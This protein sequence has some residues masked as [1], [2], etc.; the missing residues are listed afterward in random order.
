MAIAQIVDEWKRAGWEKCPRC[1]VFF[2][3]LHTY[4]TDE[5][6]CGSCSDFLKEFPQHDY[7][8]RKEN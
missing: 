4:N 5:T 8:T 7:R 3:P 6:H 2:H 1:G